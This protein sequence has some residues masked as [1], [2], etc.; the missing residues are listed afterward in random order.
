MTPFVLLLFGISFTG[1]AFLCFVVTMQPLWVIQAQ[2]RNRGAVAGAVTK[3]N[4]PLA[5]LRVGLVGLSI[6]VIVLTLS[7][8]RVT[9]TI[10]HAARDFHV[11]VDGGGE[12]KVLARKNNGFLAMTWTAAAFAWIALTFV[13]WAA[14]EIARVLKRIRQG[15]VDE[16]A[17]A[18]GRSEIT[19]VTK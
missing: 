10:T 16:G 8:A 6:V 13:V 15:R 14:F 2:I 1:T 3:D 11:D 4:F 5:P 17:V 7:A 18:D 19:L 12:L 9:N